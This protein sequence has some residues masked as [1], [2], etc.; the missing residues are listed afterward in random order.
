MPGTFRGGIIHRIMHE[1][2]RDEFFW[3]IVIPGTDYTVWEGM[4]SNTLSQAIAALLLW[5]ICCFAMFAWYRIEK[6]TKT[7]RS[8]SHED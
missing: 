1:P 7:D 6:W 8:K 2:F 3:R 4:I 5:A